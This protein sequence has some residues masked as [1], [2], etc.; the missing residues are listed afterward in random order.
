M[1]PAKD[2]W[3]IHVFLNYLLFKLI[4]LS[5]LAASKIVIILII[6][7]PVWR[8]TRNTKIVIWRLEIQNTFEFFRIFQAFIIIFKLIMFLFY[9][10]FRKRIKWRWRAMN[11]A[12]LEFV[13]C[14]SIKR[15][16]GGTCETFLIKSCCLRMI[17]VLVIIIYR[18]FYLVWY[19]LGWNLNSFKLII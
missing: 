5:M 1:G 9:R 10:G 8:W 7:I 19:W 4:I 6:S 18:V 12:F 11:K 2:V 14:S 3:R 15:K 17:L 13:I 16:W